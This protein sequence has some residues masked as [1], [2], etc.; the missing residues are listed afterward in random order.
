MFDFADLTVYD[1]ENYIHD[2]K[3]RTGYPGIDTI[4]ST[5]YYIYILNNTHSNA[6]NPIYDYVGKLKK[7]LNIV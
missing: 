4:Y 6:K 5:G 7:A 3:D 1:N 2:K